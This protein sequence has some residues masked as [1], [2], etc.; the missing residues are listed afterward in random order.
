MRSDFARSAL[1]AFGVPFFH[2]RLAFETSSSALL[3]AS[4]FGSVGESAALA[5]AARGGGGPGGG[6]T[7]K[8]SVDDNRL[9]SGGARRFPR[10]R[11]GPDF[12]R[13]GRRRASRRLWG[14]ASPGGGATTS[15]GLLE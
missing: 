12:I 3:F 9:G 15:R 11:A 5:A 8:D 10:R 2:S 13:S 1:A 14:I 6:G 7:F 4:S